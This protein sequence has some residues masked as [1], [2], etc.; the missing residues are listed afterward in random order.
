MTSISIIGRGKMGSAIADIAARA[1]AS[2]QIVN[3]SAKP[4]GGHPEAT[5][6]ALGDDLTGD[7]VVLAVP[8]SAYPNIL[9]HYRDRLGGK[10]VIDISNTIDFS[11]YEQPEALIGTSTALELARQLP[12]DV[13]VLKAFNVNLADT[14]ITRTNG[15][16]ATT[17]LFAGDDA[18]GKIALADLL[19]AAGLRAIDAGPL[20]RSKQLEAIGF[21]QMVLASTGK[22]R[23]ESGF[24]L[25][26]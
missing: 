6:A 25:L 18:E 9:K 14:L 22:T 2:I 26:P 1:G 11:T 8:Y 17:V 10:V 21:L 3:R 23:Y 5:Y 15:T 24:T 7:L 20:P 16:T 4:T 13:A 12:A 19:Q